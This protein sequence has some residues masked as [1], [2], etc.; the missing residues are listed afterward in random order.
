[1]RIPGKV[2]D[3]VLIKRLTERMKERILEK[4]KE[5]SSGRAI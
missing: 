5:F 3:R 2:Y 1:M 4:Q